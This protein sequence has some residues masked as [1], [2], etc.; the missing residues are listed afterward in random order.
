MVFTPF[1]KDY[2]HI[3]I[4]IENNGITVTRAFFSR[5]SSIPNKLN[6]PRINAYC[7]AIETVSRL[8]TTLIIARNGLIVF[9]LDGCMV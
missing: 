8:H 5:F 6:Q 1:L 2:V 3:V 7:Y 4:D 9:V